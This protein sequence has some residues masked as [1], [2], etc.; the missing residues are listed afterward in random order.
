VVIRIEQQKRTCAP[1]NP[2]LKICVPLWEWT[3]RPT[4][5]IGVDS[6]IGSPPLSPLSL[7]LPYL[8]QRQRL[9]LLRARVPGLA[10]ALLRSDVLTVTLKSTNGAVVQTNKNVPRLGWSPGQ[11]PLSS[12]CPNVSNTTLCQVFA[13]ARPSKIDSLAFTLRLPST[14][15]PSDVPQLE[16][17]RFFST[18][19]SDQVFEWNIQSGTVLVGQ[20]SPVIYA[21]H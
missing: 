19:G 6:S 11:V 9:F 17:L 4:E 18:S 5:C 2:S 12:P 16:D 7:S 14:F 1:S 13:G 15:P 8:P 21:F 3:L 20:V 10:S